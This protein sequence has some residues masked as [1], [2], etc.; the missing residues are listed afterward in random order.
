M[1]KKKRGGGHRAETLL[2]FPHQCTIS[3]ESDSVVGLAREARADRISVMKALMNHLLWNATKEAPL[4]MEIQI[5]RSSF[6]KP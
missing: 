6:P 1:Y 3:G 4:T 5:V 2:N